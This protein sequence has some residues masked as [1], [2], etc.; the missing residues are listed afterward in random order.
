MAR[1]GARRFAQVQR[2]VLLVAL[3]CLL[4]DAAPESCV[5]LPTTRPASPLGGW[6]VSYPSLADAV[7]AAYGAGAAFRCLPH[8]CELVDARNA[9]LG[10][11]PDGGCNGLASTAV[12]APC[13]DG[14]ELSFTS[15]L[16]LMLLPRGKSV[17]DAI[18][19][20]LGERGCDATT[21][22]E[23]AWWNVTAFRHATVLLYQDCQL[24]SA[25]GCDVPP[26]VA[27]L[28]A[29]GARIIHAWHY[30]DSAEPFDLFRK[31]R[32]GFAR[33]LRVPHIKYVVK[34]DTDTTLFPDRLLH[35]LRTLHA[36]AGTAQSV[37]FGTR[38]GTLGSY[39]QGGVYGFNRAGLLATRNHWHRL[40]ASVTAVVSTPLWFEDY[41]VGLAAALGDVAFVHCGHFVW[42]A[43]WYRRANTATA[44]PLPVRPITLHKA[45]SGL[46][47][48]ANH[49]PGALCEAWRDDAQPWACTWQ[50]EPPQL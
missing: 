5:A 39:M 50:T 15:V 14:M 49:L 38:D 46:A 18:Q 23:G 2:V 22:V 45:R 37:Y 33:A 27:A 12:A 28:R 48:L 13:D 19:H 42:T 40:N 6:Q 16:L 36:A 21:C 11:K 29:D 32:L 25:E 30:V 47:S 24:D 8:N 3:C 17:S 26:D 31:V 43:E 7:D 34:I 10:V 9:S 35:F 44:Y 4:S 1:C 20:E 41:L